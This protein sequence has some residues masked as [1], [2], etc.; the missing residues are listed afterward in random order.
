[1]RTDLKKETVREQTDETRT[2][3]QENW[4]GLSVEK[5]ME[6]FS[7]TRVERL[8]SLFRR[9]LPPGG[10]ILEGGCGLGPWVIKL[11][12]LGYDITGVDYDDVSVHKIR[13]YDPGAGL[14]VCNVKKMPFEDRSFDAY[15]SLGVLEHFCEGP[16][17]A[18]AE[19]W[20]VLDSGGLF[21]VMLP[22][23]NIFERLRLPAKNIKKNAFIRKILGREKKDFYY[24]KYFSLREI[25]TILE[26]AGFEVEETL[27]IDHI[28]TLVSFSGI[29]RDA[30]TYD[31]ENEL[32]VR[33]ADKLSSFLPWQSAG[34]SFLVARKVDK[35]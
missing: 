15:L 18:V 8:L 11:R 19:A 32:A 28:F 21:L 3:W 26:N 5:V 17:E 30:E 33:F 24:E 35:R 12:S 9:Y 10:R 7:Y 25:T 20:R 27:P 13:K 2:A 14:C 31:G 23:L 6:I 1:M 16:A 29:F 34:S 4:S 22:Y